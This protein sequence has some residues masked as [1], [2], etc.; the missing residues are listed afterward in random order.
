MPL[1]LIAQI[2]K[3]RVM[4]NTEKFKTKKK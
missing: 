1:K 3:F 4:V 2:V